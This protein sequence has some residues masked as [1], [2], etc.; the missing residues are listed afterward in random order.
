M[1]CLHLTEAARIYLPLPM[2]CKLAQQGVNHNY[3][4][5]IHIMRWREKGEGFVIIVF[6][7]EWVVTAAHCLCNP[8]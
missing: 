4:D 1:V 7:R 6:N 2:W 8:K 5:A 3:D